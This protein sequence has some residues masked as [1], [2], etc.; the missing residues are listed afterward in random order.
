[1]IMMIIIM[2]MMIM[3]KIMMMKMMIMIMIMIVIVGSCIT[4]MS[5][6]LTPLA[7]HNYY[8]GF[9]LC[10]VNYDQHRIIWLNNHYIQKKMSLI[11][12]FNLQNILTALIFKAH[13][14]NIGLQHWTTKWH[15]ASFFFKDWYTS[16]AFCY[17]R[18]VLK[19]CFD[20]LSLF[21]ARMPLPTSWA[22][23]IIH[24]CQAGTTLVALVALDLRGGH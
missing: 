3:M 19:E 24:S 11:V 20:C 12:Y 15:K 17:W 7:L 14:L 21:V 5:I 10:Y 22:T 8:P 23:E 1:M 13:L 16:I 9:S 6:R 4:L 18:I 2:V